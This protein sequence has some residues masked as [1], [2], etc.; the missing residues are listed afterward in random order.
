MTTTEVALALSV[1]RRS[2]TDGLLVLVPHPPDMWNEAVAIADRVSVH[3]RTQDALHAACA[4]L[5]GLGLA[6]FDADLAAAARSE[7][8][9][10]LP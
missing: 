2:V 10:V 9:S 5:N 7:G 3:L 1:L 6:T 8:L 4:K